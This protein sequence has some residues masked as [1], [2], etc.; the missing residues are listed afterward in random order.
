MFG[1]TF[2]HFDNPKLNRTHSPIYE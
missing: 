1:A 2:G